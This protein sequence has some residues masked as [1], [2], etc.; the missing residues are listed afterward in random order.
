MFPLFHLV[1]YRY[2]KT[3]LLSE[4]WN[5]TTDL[6]PSPHYPIIENVN[7]SRHFCLPSPHKSRHTALDSRR[8][9]ASWPWF[10]PSEPYLQNICA[11]R[12]S[13][14][15]VRTFYFYYLGLERKLTGYV[16]WK[17]ELVQTLAAKLADNHNVT[18]L[19]FQP[20]YL[21]NSANRW[22]RARHFISFSAEHWIFV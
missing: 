19:L 2:W 4:Y 17:F 14:T 11:K 21:C 20:S 8:R 5:L 13:P 15:F 3:H 10:R 22:E 6:L 18:P 16:K 12:T 1:R 9:V 7:L